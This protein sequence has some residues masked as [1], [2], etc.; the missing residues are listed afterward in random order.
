MGLIAPRHVGSSQT[1]DQISVS[2]I[3]RQIRAP[4]GKSPYTWVLKHP[5]SELTRRLCQL[6]LW[7]FLWWSL[8]LRVRVRGRAFPKCPS[9]IDWGSIG[10][11]EPTSS[12]VPVNVQGRNQASKLWIPGDK[13]LHQTRHLQPWSLLAWLLETLMCRLGPLSSSWKVVFSGS[14]RSFL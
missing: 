13:L 5:H 10:H 1:M 14:F 2:C 9:L 8:F 12:L 3:G 4:P 6:C 7:T 11:T